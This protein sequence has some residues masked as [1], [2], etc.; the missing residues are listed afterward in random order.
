MEAKKIAQTTGIPVVFSNA[1]IEGMNLVDSIREPG[2]NTT[3]VRYPGPDIALGRL[4]IMMEIVPDAKNILVPYDKNYPNVPPQLEVLRGWTPT[5]GVNLIEVPVATPAELQDYLD[6][7]AEMHQEVDAIL[8]LA[9][10]VS[11][12]P[13][14]VD[15][16]G[17]FADEN[18]IPMGGAL[19]L[20]KDGYK[21]E[22]LFGVSVDNFS[23]GSQAAVLADKIFRGIPAGTIPVVSAEMFLEINYKKALEMGIVPSE[24]ILSIADKIIR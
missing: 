11:A 20:E 10:P 22:S 1:N 14:Y 24:S 17:K 3:G 6:S 21:Y 18:N 9:E 19:L 4:E 23:V 12:D 8:T 13:I 16:F 5:A 2:N 15:V 7:L